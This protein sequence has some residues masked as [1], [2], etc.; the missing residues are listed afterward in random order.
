MQRQ[1]ARVPGA[2]LCLKLGQPLTW[3]RAGRGEGLIARHLLSGEGGFSADR[4]QLRLC[5]RNCGLLL[6]NLGARG[7][8]RGGRRCDL[9]GDLLSLGA[10]FAGV[11]FGQRLP[12]PNRLVLANEHTLTYPAILG[13]TTTE[14]AAT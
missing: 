12:L 9:A 3:F 6:G 8:T 10:S 1:P 13:A 2:R 14:A 4:A 7:F 5:L 11:E